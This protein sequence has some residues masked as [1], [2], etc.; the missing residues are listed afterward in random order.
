M[1]TATVAG[2]SRASITSSNRQETYSKSYDNQTRRTIIQKTLLST[3]LI[4]GA[5]LPAGAIGARVDPPSIASAI[6]AAKPGATVYIP[7][8][9]YNERLVLDKSI[10]LTAVPG[11]RVEVVWETSQPYEST[12]EV[13]GK[14]GDTIIIGGL[15]VRHASPSIANNYAVH[16]LEGAYVQIEG[17]D[18]TSSTGSGVGMEGDHVEVANCHIHDCARSGAMLFGDFES[19]GRSSQRMCLRNCAIERNKLHGIVVRDGAAPIV[20]G[21]ADRSNGGYGLALTD[22][23]GSYENNVIVNNK[24]G[25]L[26]YYLLD[27]INP[28]ELSEKNGIQASDM[29]E[30]RL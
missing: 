5:P 19:S 2:I 20:K 6:A 29:L 21:N 14:Q 12:I 9:I 16:I 30:I 28:D 27:G 4:Q 10:H 13:M 26:A 24:Q 3:L 17:C 15:S 18:V 22:C 1:I 11:E 25:V 7:G 23:G 8:G